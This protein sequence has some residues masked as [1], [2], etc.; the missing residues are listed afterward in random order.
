MKK[1]KAHLTING[2]E[3]ECE[4]LSSPDENKYY[5]YQSDNSGFTIWYTEKIAFTGWKS[6]N[7]L[8]SQE[9]IN[10]VGKLINES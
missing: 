8:M 5:V 2:K 3:D 4:I 7:K 1:F 6:D 10:A 9:E